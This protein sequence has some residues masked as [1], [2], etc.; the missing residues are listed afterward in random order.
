[1]TQVQICLGFEDKDWRELS[2]RLIQNRSYILLSKISIPR[3][4][5]C[6]FGGMTLPLIFSCIDV[7]ETYACRITSLSPMKRVLGHGLPVARPKRVAALW[8]TCWPVWRPTAPPWPL[9][10]AS[11]DSAYFRPLMKPELIA[12][13][14][15]AQISHAP[16][17]IA[18]VLFLTYDDR[19]FW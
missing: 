18:V 13:S 15:R 17:C 9:T 1:V 10:R 14:H 11:A 12:K 6:S 7:L 19:N 8:A 16:I 2:K 4:Q 3:C 5:S